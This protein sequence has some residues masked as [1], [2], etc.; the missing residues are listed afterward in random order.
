MIVDVDPRTVAH[1]GPTYERPYARPAGQDALQT[2]HFTGSAADDARPRGEQLGEAIKAFMASPNMCS[3]SW[4]T[5]QYDRYVQGNTAQSVEERR[6]M[7]INGNILNTLLFL[8]I[9]TL[10]VGIIQALIPLSDNFFLNNLTNV[11]VAGSVTF[12]QP[13]LNIMIALSQGLGVAATAKIGRAS[14]RERV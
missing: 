9:P 6:E 2:N 1:D 13:V 3:K 14:C 7:I 11:V 5:N 4:I 8:S 12:S 10:L